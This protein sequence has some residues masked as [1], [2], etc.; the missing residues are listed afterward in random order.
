MPQVETS[1]PRWQA[2]QIHDARHGSTSLLDWMSGTRAAEGW[3]SSTNLME[4]IITL[5]ARPVETLYEEMP[6]TLVS[7]GDELIDWSF[8]MG[9]RQALRITHAMSDHHW[10]HPELPAAVLMQYGMSSLAISAQML[11]RLSGDTVRWIYLRIP[12]SN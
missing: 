12:C 10:Y 4:T 9:G 3:T 7:S 5:F 2:V 6:E 1:G 8:Q 11:R